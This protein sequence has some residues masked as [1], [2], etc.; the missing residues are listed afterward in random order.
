M[1]YILLTVF[2]LLLSSSIHAQE[3]IIS[4]K[5]PVVDTVISIG[6]IGKSTHH[7]PSLTFNLAKKLVYA[8]YRKKG[9]C[10]SDKLPDMTNSEIKDG[11]ILCVD[12]DT[13][14]FTHLS[15]KYG[16]DAIVTFWITPPYSSGNCF[17]PHKAII[18]YNANGYQFTNED[19]IPDS[20]AIDSLTIINDRV[21]VNANQY[22]CNQHKE[23]RRLRIQLK[24]SK[25]E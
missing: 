6:G 3:N 8:Y 25:P 18:T 2:L 17:Q 21:F 12:F 10:S 11:N 16:Q 23:I 4:T 7:A 19:F 5:M 22:D 13:L 24:N 1:K 20:F 15:G 14:Y 9:Y